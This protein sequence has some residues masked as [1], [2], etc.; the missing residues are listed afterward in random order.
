MT[1]PFRITLATGY[2]ARAR[3]LWEGR[4][5]SGALELKVAPFRNDGERH[6]RFLQGEFDAAEFSLALYIA[7]KSRGAPLQAIP[8]FPNRKFRHSYVFVREDSALREMG[9]LKGKR[10]GI[11]TYLNTCGLWVR[12]LLSE[13]YGIKVWEISWR[14][15]ER[16]R[17][18]V[19]LPPGTSVELLSGAGD[20][21]SRLLGGEVDAI[22]VPDLPRTEG[23]RSLI[24]RSK[25]IEKDYYRRTGIFPISHVV[26]IRRSSLD[27]RPSAA[28]ELYRIWSEAKRLAVE[29]DEDPTYSNF[30]WIRGLWE[31]QREVLGPDPWRYGIAGNERV[32]EALI[33]YAAEQGIAEGRASANDFFLDVGESGTG[34]NLSMA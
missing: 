26:V 10:V 6:R 16:E 9:E 15:L 7:L 11:P 18:A 22:V 3:P 8:V 33:R 13:E 4:V 31:E 17:V 12:G 34:A 2:H 1:G 20:P 32:I 27:E 14:T 5:Q 23:I 30:A 19:S 29:D 25:E 21:A 24:S 28:G